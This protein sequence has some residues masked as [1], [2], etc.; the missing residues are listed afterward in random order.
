MKM[1]RIISLLFASFLFSGCESFF[2][3][4]QEEDLLKRPEAKRCGECH[5]NIYNQWKDSRH[6]K[7]WIS[8]GYRK[9]TNNYRKTKCFNCHIPYEIKIGEK[10]DF[11]EKHRDD[12]INCVSCHFREDTKSMH[13]E[14]DV[15]SPPHPSTKDI[16]YSTSKICSG[17]H[18][19]TYK[20]WEETGVRKECQDCHMPSKTGSL[21]Q[22][23][24]FEYLHRKKEVHNH[25]FP[26]GIIKEQDIQ[27]DAE[28]LGRKL[29]IT[30]KNVSIPHNIPTAD[31]GKPKLYLTVIFK[32]KDDEVY[33]DRYMFTPKDPVFY[34]K[35]RVL[36][37]KSFENFDSVD[38]ILERKL[39]HQ[40]IKEKIL[41]IERRFD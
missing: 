29:F 4:F 28:K 25:S 40:K 23:F 17:C 10:P 37:F 13:G 31:N 21:I 1:K 6:S 34:K 33:I 22:K 3:I 32:E 12:G 5:K 39:S 30:I 18:Q 19:K 14:Y 38:I 27:I 24:P 8:E 41:E 9:V 7:S 36:T 16:N 20:Q 2:K 11:R 35:E 15:F 26:T